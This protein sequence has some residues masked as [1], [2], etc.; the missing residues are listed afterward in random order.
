MPP[1][2]VLLSSVRACFQSVMLAPKSL[3][4]TAHVGQETEVSPSSH[5]LPSPQDR[6]NFH[7]TSVLYR[8][9]RTALESWSGAEARNW[10]DGEAIAPTHRRSSRVET[11]PAQSHCL[12]TVAYKV[13]LLFSL[14]NRRGSQELSAGA[15]HMPL[16]CTGLQTGH[17]HEIT[18]QKSS[19]TP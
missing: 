3:Q 1:W 18:T 12:G 17:H 6:N 10:G 13:D 8:R 9:P 15:G 11:V 2:P 4:Q 19:S 14:Q 7:T 16:A 5:I